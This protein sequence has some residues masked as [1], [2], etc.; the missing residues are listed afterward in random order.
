MG[1]RSQSKAMRRKARIEVK[2]GKRTYVVGIMPCDN[3]G[4]TDIT[5]CHLLCGKLGKIN[6]DRA[7]QEAG[8]AQP[9]SR[10]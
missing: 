3:S 4:N 9:S 1:I 8:Q 7:G 6:A 5:G 2:M 10:W